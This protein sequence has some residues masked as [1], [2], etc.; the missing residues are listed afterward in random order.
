MTDQQE[1]TYQQQ[2]RDL[3]DEVTRLKEEIEYFKR[4]LFGSSSEK[5]RSKE[6]PGQLSLFDEAETYADPKAPEPTLEEIKGYTRRRY[7]GQKEKLLA[8]LKHS[9]EVAT[10]A[11]ED[12]ICPICGSELVPVGR[13]FVRTEVQ[14]IPAELKVIDHY[15]ETYECRNCRKNGKPYFE[16]SPMPYAPIFHSLASASTIA[17]VIH[18]KFE[19]A[20]PLYRQEQEWKRLGL[21]LSRATLCNWL[22]ATYR[23]WFSYVVNLLKQ[24]LFKQHYLHIDETP[25]QVLHEPG[26]ANTTKSYMW[27]YT[28]IEGCN[29][30]VR[31]FDYRTGRSGKYPQDMLKGFSGYIH[32]DAYSGYNDLPNVKRCF[33]WVHLRRCFFDALPKDLKDPSATKPAMALQYIGKLFELEEKFKDLSPEDRKVKRPEQ[34][35]PVLDAFFAWVDTSSIGVLPKSKLGE[36]Y[37]YAQ[38]QK[39]G[40]MT[41]LEDGTCVISNQMAENSIRPFTI[42]RKNWLF[43]GSPKGAAASAGIYTLI[44]TAK[45]N[46]LQPIKYIQ[47]ILETMPGSNFLQDHS[48][49]E[50]YLPWNPEVQKICS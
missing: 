21:E 12:R 43:S 48:I 39:D 3:T 29:H 30:P 11:P 13:E 47:Y 35:K 2:I 22:M 38:N 32:T 19:L 27:V 50:E 20:V 16:K 6:I 33:C 31:L 15:R 25:V 45:A 40:L 8:N 41:Y 26:R 17:W 14:Y 34:E 24:E 28:S 10:L 18:Q 42:G 37:T 49:L 4:K 36:A 9:V 7:E 23:D 46:G 1:Q 44:E 5:L